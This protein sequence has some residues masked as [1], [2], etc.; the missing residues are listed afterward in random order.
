MTRDEFLSTVWKPYPSLPLQGK[1][2]RYGKV[3][4]VHEH[5]LVVLT[6][7]LEDWPK[8]LEGE[9]SRV[10]DPDLGSSIPASFILVGD[11]IGQPELPS[12]PLF[13]LSPN[14]ESGW[15]APLNENWQNFLQ[16]VHRFFSSRGF[17]HWVTPYLVSSSG[18]DA[19]I[20]FLTVKGVR[21][22]REFS[23]PTSPEFALKKVL[24]SGQRKIF[25]IKSCFRDDDGSPT[26]KTEF[27]MIEWYRA[28][29]KKWALVEDFELLLRDLAPFFDVEPPAVLRVSM[30]ELFK[31]HVGID[32]HPGTPAE[33]L[34]GALQSRG[35]HQSPSDDWDDLFFR[36]FV[37][38]IEPHLGHNAP[39]VVYDFPLSQA[40]LSRRTDSGWA[41]RFEIYWNGVE[42]ANAYQ[43]QNNPHLVLEV[44]EREIAKRIQLG[45]TPP[46]LDKDFHAAMRSGFPP[47]TGVAL[48]LDRLF[49]VLQKNKS[50]WDHNK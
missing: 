46:K 16:H 3:L 4:A 50:L 47:S 40:S 34:S 7:S 20:D 41:D 9:E 36:L 45:R 17:T 10:L 43:E 42:L 32:L 8:P 28:Y 2:W 13:L 24:A 33:E 44:S 48:G 1:G 5:H 35:L 19:H 23:L 21:T 22:G 15:I 26:H 12:G 39:T 49:M 37:D 6:E 18:V 14:L 38:C 11:C 30:T 29:E 31:T 25:E 27:T